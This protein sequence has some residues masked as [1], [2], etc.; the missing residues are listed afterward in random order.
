M[1][2][3]PLLASLPLIVVWTGVVVS[4]CRAPYLDVMRVL[5]PSDVWAIGGPTESD[6][7]PRNKWSVAG[8]LGRRLSV[9]VASWGQATGKD[10]SLHN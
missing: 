10:K 1:I 5:K 4:Q 6:K 9:W 3:Q 8:W 2:M 7:K